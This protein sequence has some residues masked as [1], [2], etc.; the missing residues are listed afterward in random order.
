NKPYQ[1]Q[2]SFKSALAFAPDVVVIMLGTNDTKP[3]NWQFK[4]EFI[5]D[6]QN[7]IG[8]FRELDSEPKIILCRPPHV[9][10]EGNFGIN[11][12]ALLELLPMVD[13]V[14]ETEKVPTID[15]Y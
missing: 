6:Y 11:E 7:L 14:A 10:G 1:Q 8:K 4:N 13:A 12:P 5:A 15:V 9:P 2:E 3:Q